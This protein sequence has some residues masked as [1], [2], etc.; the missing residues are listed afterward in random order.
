[1]ISVLRWRKA[2]G[3]V[4]QSGVSS[5]IMRT[6]FMVLALFLKTGHAEQTAKWLSE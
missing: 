2:S 4:M 6:G 1:M 5:K 3:I